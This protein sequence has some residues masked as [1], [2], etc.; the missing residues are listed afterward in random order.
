MRMTGW[1]Q[2]FAAACVTISLSSEAPAQE[3]QVYLANA[4]LQQTISAQLSAQ[5]YQV[6]EIRRTLLGRVQFIAVRGTAIREVIVS[7]S[8]GEILR[9]VTMEDVGRATV[10]GNNPASGS[11]SSGSSGGG[12]GETVENAG[13]SVGEA[14]G[15][16]GNAVGGLVDG[17]TG[18]VGGVVNDLGL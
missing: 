10:P 12:L 14:A 16:I 3:A 6:V 15:G 9:D 7:R 11:G 4:S 2:I 5:G 13:N 1:I 17:A 18:A 8:T